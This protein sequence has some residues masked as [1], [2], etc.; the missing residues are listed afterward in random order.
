MLQLTVSEDYSW[1]DRRL[2]QLFLSIVY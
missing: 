1:I 2:Q